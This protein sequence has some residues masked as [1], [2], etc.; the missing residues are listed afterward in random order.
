MNSR[1]AADAVPVEVHV[2]T[3]ESSREAQPNTSSGCHAYRLAEGKGT[4]SGLRSGSLAS[5]TAET[6]VYECGYVSASR[7]VTLTR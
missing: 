6:M 2:P 4:P 7:A 3:I 1:G 5:A